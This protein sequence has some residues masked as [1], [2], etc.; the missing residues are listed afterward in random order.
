MAGQGGHLQVDPRHLLAILRVYT[1]GFHSA[2]DEHDDG[3]KRARAVIAIAEHGRVHELKVTADQAVAA[4]AS[5]T[6]R[7][8]GTMSSS[9]S[10]NGY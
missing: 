6:I 10:T 2:S 8:S 1:V 7:A 3:L 4:S 5:A 9:L